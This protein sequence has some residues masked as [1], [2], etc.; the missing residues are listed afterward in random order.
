MIE[1]YIES[2]HERGGSEQKRVERK[3]HILL[4]KLIYW[5]ELWINSL[6]SNLGE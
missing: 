3:S 6:A 2:N 4:K 5:S 1:I